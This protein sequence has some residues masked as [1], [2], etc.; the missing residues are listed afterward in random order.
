MEYLSNGE[1]NIPELDN[2]CSYLLTDGNDIP[3]FP[4]LNTCRDNQEFSNFT[5]PHTFLDPLPEKKKKKVFQPYAVKNKMVAL[6]KDDVERILHRISVES[7]SNFS[8]VRRGV[9]SF[10]RV[11]KAEKRGPGKDSIREEIETSVNRRGEN[12][13]DQICSMTPVHPHIST[14]VLDK[15]SL[16][17]LLAR[18]IYE[19]HKQRSDMREKSVIQHPG[20]SI[21]KNLS[22]KN[23]DVV[24]WASEHVDIIKSSG[25]FSNNDYLIKVVSRLSRSESHL[26][27]TPDPFILS[28]P[29]SP[30]RINNPSQMWNE[31]LPAVIWYRFA[32]HIIKAVLLARTSG[33]SFE[34]CP[35]YISTTASSA[36]G[37]I[38]WVPTSV[39]GVV[40]RLVDLDNFMKHVW[41]QVQFVV[42]KD[43]SGVREAR[44]ASNSVVNRVSLFPRGK[45]KEIGVPMSPTGLGAFMPECMTNSRLPK[46]LSKEVEYLDQS[47]K[48]SNSPIYKYLKREET[49]SMNLKEALKTLRKTWI[50]RRNLVVM[51]KVLK[52]GTPCPH[53]NC[54]C[55]GLVGE[56]KKKM[57]GWGDKRKALSFV[58]DILESTLHILGKKYSEQNRIVPSL[59]YVTST[60]M[61]TINGYCEKLLSDQASKIAEM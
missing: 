37:F 12:Q 2:L 14:E 28:P 40:I 32:S 22:K 24:K 29:K 46:S 4:P 36:R 53:K 8:R 13:K 56:L 47:N 33:D 54:L 9:A 5:F 20:Y 58:V 60:H 26:F 35:E 39:G 21:L 25:W 11:L 7:G 52:P 45:K 30:E 23:V 31:I 6:S 19:D 50:N 44:V 10:M 43:K 1:V 16:C 17:R 38:V 15:D 51:N 3:E 41:P 49:L 34:S 57:L 55:H 42:N 59:V 18:S 27:M 61:E 48:F